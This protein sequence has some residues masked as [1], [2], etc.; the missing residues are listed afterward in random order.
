MINTK[1]LEKSDNTR[2]FLDGSKRSVVILDSVA[3]GK[4]EYLPGWRWSKHVG[5]QT[6]KPSEAHIGLVISGQFVIK[7]PDG[8]E[9]TVGPGDAFESGPNHDAWVLGDKLCIALDFEYLKK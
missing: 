4:G 5:P 2:T 8:K 6:G 7:A 9:T 3:I 1:N